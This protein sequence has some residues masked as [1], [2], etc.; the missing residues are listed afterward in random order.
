VAN[1]DLDDRSECGA[2]IGGAVGRRRRRGGMRGCVLRH[3]RSIGTEGCGRNFATG[4]AVCPATT[5]KLLKEV[6]GASEF[7]PPTS[8]SRIRQ[9]G[10][11]P[12]STS[13]DHRA[14][15]G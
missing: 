9:S 13:G 1:V 11:R 2:R 14:A 15:F 7:E 4:W 12:S 6:V 5:C 3:A 8:W 10:R